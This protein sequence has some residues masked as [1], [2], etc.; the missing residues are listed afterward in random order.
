VENKKIKKTSYQIPCGFFKIASISSGYCYV[1][2]DN[3]FFHSL[4]LIA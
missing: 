3:F 4:T 2:F 1:V